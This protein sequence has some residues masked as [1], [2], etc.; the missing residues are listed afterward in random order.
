[1]QV[2]DNLDKLTNDELLTAFINHSN[3]IKEETLCNEL[4]LVINGIEYIF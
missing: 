1:M 4:A 3:F 2:N